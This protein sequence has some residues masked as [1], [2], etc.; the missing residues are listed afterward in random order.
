LKGSLLYCHEGSAARLYRIPDSVFKEYRTLFT[1]PPELVTTEFFEL[2]NQINHGKIETL[3]A[4][5]INGFIADNL[6]QFDLVI[7]LS[8]SAL[9]HGTFPFG[10]YELFCP[11]TIGI[12]QC[13]YSKS[14]GAASWYILLSSLMIREV[15]SQTL[16]LE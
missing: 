6:N 16:G 9:P 7:A 4:K 8:I 3:G 14:T 15:D 13:L 11:F 2:R 12:V 1:I 5:I 10:T